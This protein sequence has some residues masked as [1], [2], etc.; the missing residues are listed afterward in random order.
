MTLRACGVQ[1]TYWG[2]D[3]IALQYGEGSEQVSHEEPLKKESMSPSTSLEAALEKLQAEQEKKSK[4]EVEEL[5]KELYRE[6]PFYLRLLLSVDPVP[7]A[8]YILLGLMVGL[9]WLQWYRPVGW[10]CVAGLILCLHTIL[11]IHLHHHLFTQQ[12]FP[13]GIVE[14]EPGWGLFALVGV[15]GAFYIL[16]LLQPGQL[17]RP[18][19]KIPGLAFPLVLVGLILLGRD[20]LLTSK[21]VFQVSSGDIEQPAATPAPELLAE[22]RHA[23]TISPAEVQTEHYD[24]HIEGLDA[25]EVGRLL[26]QAYDNL[27]R[28]FRAAPNDRLR[29]ELYE[30]QDALLDILK[31]EGVSPTD[32]GGYYSPR[33]KTAIL[34]VQPSDYATRHLLLHEATH[35]FHH[36]AVTGNQP[37]SGFWYVE[38]LAEYFAM[39]NWDGKTLQVGV[40]PAI[41]LEDYPAQ[42]LQEVTKRN[43]DLQGLIQGTWGNR[44]EGW[45][46]IHY[47][48]NNEP[49]R[50]RQLARL[51]D[52][53]VEPA[54]AW[55]QVFGEVTVKQANAWRGWLE[56]HQQ[57]WRV[58][59]ISFQQIGDVLEGKAEANGLALL[60]ETPPRLD[61]EV[62]LISGKL[63]AG[64]V[65][66][67]QS[68]DW[69]HLWQVQANNT[70]RLVECKDGKWTIGPS[71]PLPRSKEQPR[72]ALVQS[73]KTVT[74]YAN[75]VKLVTVTASGQVGLN[76]EGCRVHFRVNTRKA[77][78]SI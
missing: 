4:E 13:F 55:R 73:D 74:L 2:I 3:W 47:L 62:E 65:F 66:G 27:Q 39:H 29:L 37:P 12:A 36:L 70:V 38:G 68:P 21:K 46:L 17:R 34:V 44:P 51:L 35:Q 75:G 57:P 49:H 15:W 31:A 56:Q 20:T 19:K 1:Q 24:L 58:V 16:N 25:N 53:H 7:E 10:L 61:V 72:L 67:Y 78:S 5:L 18:T 71:Y 11:N 41:T 32:V 76:V 59:W 77:D 64:L 26:E 6:A 60:K 52:R 28:F 14:I 69:F 40:I 54:A 23:K 48:V 8:S 43:G 45:S 63:L 33:R 42:A 30:K 9:A 50:F 22:L